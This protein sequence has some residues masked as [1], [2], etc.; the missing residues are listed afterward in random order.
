MVKYKK[1]NVYHVKKRYMLRKYSYD[2]KNTRCYCGSYLKTIMRENK[3]DNDEVEKVFFKLCIQTG[4]S[5]K[6]C[7]ID[8]DSDED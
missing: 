4:Q 7:K 3:N 5:P 6:K 2:S 1:K 8:G